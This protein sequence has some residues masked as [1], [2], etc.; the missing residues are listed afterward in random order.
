MNTGSNSEYAALR[1]QG[2]SHWEAVACIKGREEAAMN[3]WPRAMQ[4]R[5]LTF[6]HVDGPS[7]RWLW[8]I[9]RDYEDCQAYGEIIMAFNEDE[10]LLPTRAEVRVIMRALQFGPHM[11]GVEFAMWDNMMCQQLPVKEIV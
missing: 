7:D 2:L 4:I 9:V 3:Q 6:A 8:A 5:D 11:V 10:D 1:Q